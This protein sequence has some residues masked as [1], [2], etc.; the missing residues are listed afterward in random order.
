MTAAGALVVG[1]AVAV[2]AM[3]DPHPQRGVIVALGLA[4]VVALG[5]A[6]WLRV[7]AGVGAYLLGAGAAWA[8]RWADAGRE[9]GEGAPVVAAGLWL[10]AELAWWALERRGPARTD[11]AAT[12]RRVAWTAGVVGLTLAV[13]TFLLEV[14]GTRPGGGLTTQ[15][16][17]A[18]AT[19]VALAVVAALAGGRRTVSR[20]RE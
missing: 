18:A 2:A 19:A 20:G 11:A 15:A 6:L 4:A 10:A 7:T 12:A 3:V 1:A 8:L 5:L 17:G 9:V 13:G 16:I 14:A